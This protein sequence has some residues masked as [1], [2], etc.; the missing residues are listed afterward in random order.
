[1]PY[2]SRC[3][4][5]VDGDVK[6]CP[7]CNTP[8]QRFED[9][10]PGEARYPADEVNPKPEMSEGMRRR[11]LW[12]VLT[13]LCAISVIVVIGSDLRIDSTVDWSLYPTLS[14]ALAWIYST[15]IIFFRRQVPTLI[16]GF[17]VSTIAYL[18]AIDLV[19]G[20]FEWFF[21]LGLPIF[22]LFGIVAGV[23]IL[24]ALKAKE[25]GLNVVA[26]IMIGAAVFCLVVNLLV[27]L[28]LSGGVHFTWSI[29]VVLTLV[30]MAIILLFLHY[31]LRNRFDL[32]R[33]FHM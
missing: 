4:V 13:L 29:V 11:I 12:E 15:L 28:Y 1:M 32:K 19:D 17:I 33:V 23:E 31:R 25:R 24:V 27:S 9:N 8:I 21:S 30:P 16:V 5:E 22:A 3:G 2:C 6:N 20:S 10:E 26:F 7:L 18:A 14:I